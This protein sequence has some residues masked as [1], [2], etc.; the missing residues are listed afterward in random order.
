ME[1]CENAPVFDRRIEIAMSRV[2][3]RAGENCRNGVMTDQ[4]QRRETR[5]PTGSSSSYLLRWENRKFFS[6]EGRALVCFE[7]STV[8][9]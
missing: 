8:L 4:Q 6:S 5:S 2:E 7:N 1:V 9:G 3:A